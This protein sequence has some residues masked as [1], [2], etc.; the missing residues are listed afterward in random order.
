MIDTR[1]KDVA[2]A[3]EQTADGKARSEAKAALPA[4]QSASDQMLA[5]IDSLAKDPYLPN[6]LGPIN[7][8]TPNL[9][10]DAARV[11][12]KMD[13]ING[14][15]F[16]QAF[17][18]LATGLLRSIRSSVWSTLRLRT[19]RPPSERRTTPSGRAAVSL[20]QLPKVALQH[21]AVSA[22]RTPLGGFRK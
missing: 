22:P 5:T 13:Q 21:Q 1:E 4:I 17:K 19:H 18:A 3:A 7:S 11:Q 9:T 8:R 14:Q 20:T 10:S 16:L 15:T 6:M 12:S 2:G